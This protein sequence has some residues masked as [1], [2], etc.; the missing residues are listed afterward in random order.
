MQF[1]VLQILRI[2]DDVLENLIPEDGEPQLH[3][4]PRTYQSKVNEITS[5]YK[6][7][8]SGIKKADC[9]LVNKTRNSNSDFVRFLQ[10]PAIPRRRPDITAFI[11]KPLEHYREVLKLFNVILSNTKTN[12]EDY[13]VLSKT[14]QDLQV[15]HLVCRYI[16][17]NISKCFVCL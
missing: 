12:H 16:Y 11:H 8:C 2:T 5:A 4:L 10:T 6:R 13:Q 14:V 7:Y 17:C 1:C 9:I 15:I 3:L